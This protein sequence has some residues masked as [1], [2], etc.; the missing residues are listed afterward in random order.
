MKHLKAIIAS[1]ALFVMFAGTTVQVL[2]NLNIKSITFDFSVGKEAVDNDTNLKNLKWH[3][4]HVDSVKDINDLIIR[5]N[6]GIILVR[7]DKHLDN[8]N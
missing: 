3:V 8:L 6:T 4:W 5:Q 2:D 7:N 1:I